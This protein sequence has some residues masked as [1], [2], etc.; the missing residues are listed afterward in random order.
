MKTLAPIVISVR[1][2]KPVNWTCECDRDAIQ[3]GFTPT[4][5]RKVPAK[6]R[7]SVIAATSALEAGGIPAALESDGDQAD[8]D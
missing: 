4:V 1:H 2:G 6:F 5:G 3:F 8:E 7:A